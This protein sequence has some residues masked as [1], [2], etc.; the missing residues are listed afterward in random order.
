MRIWQGESHF[1]QKC[2]LANVGKSV[3]H[4]LV[5]VASLASTCQD[6]WRVWQFCNCRLDHFIY[7]YKTT[8]LNKFAKFAKLAKFAKFAEHSLNSPFMSLASPRKTVWQMSA[9]LASPRKSG[10]FLANTQIC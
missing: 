7:M 5:N 2:N 8:T 9:G 3:Q 1:S 10:Y 6:A 4:G